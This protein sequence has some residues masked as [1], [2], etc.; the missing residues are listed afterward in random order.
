MVKNNEKRLLKNVDIENGL[1]VTLSM[2]KAYPMQYIGLI[3]LDGKPK[4]KAFEFKFEENGVLYFDTIRN[5]ETHLELL[6]NP[7]VEICV[8]DRETMEWIRMSG[9]VKFVE[10]RKIKEKLFESSEILR[11][12]YGDATNDDVL[13][14]CLEDVIVQVSGSDLNNKVYT[15]HL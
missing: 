14:F 8:A 12:Y 13:P 2:L 11:Q 3:G 10:D 6:K 9:K 4:V 15:Y 5:K 1:E 7:Y